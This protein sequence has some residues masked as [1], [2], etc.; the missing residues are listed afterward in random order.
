MRFGSR[1]F[2][3]ISW[4]CKKQTAQC[5]ICSSFIGRGLENGGFTSRITIVGLYWKHFSH[6]DAQETPSPP[7]GRGH[8][9]SLC[10]DH[11]SN[12]PENSF[13][14]WHHIFVDNEAVIHMTIQG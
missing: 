5:R 7:S 6:S 8:C 2:V 4:M 1:T 3:P 10:V 13:P 11:M 12:I 9:L 14:V